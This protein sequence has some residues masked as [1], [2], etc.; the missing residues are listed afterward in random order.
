M[1][2]GI[3]SLESMKAVGRVGL[4]ALVHFEILTTI[5][6]V[7]ALVIALIIGLVVVNVVKP[8]HGLHVDP[9]TL[10][11]SG[12]PEAATAQHESFADFMLSIIFG[13]GIQAVGETGTGIKRRVES[14]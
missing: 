2:H 8:G 13:F 14:L 6:L 4:K 11:T 10:S 12:P 1:V 5:A 3:S 7:I 9:S